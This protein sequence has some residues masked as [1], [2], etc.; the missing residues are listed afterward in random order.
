MNKLLIVVLCMIAGSAACPAAD[1]N[2]AAPA[3][4]D[5]SKREISRMIETFRTAIVAKDRAGL[6]GLPFGEHIT[7]ASVKDAADLA[8]RRKEHPEVQKAKPGSYADFVDYIV[9]SKERDEEKFSNIRIRTDGSI[10][11]VYFDYSFSVD[12][13]VTNRGHETWG[14]VDTDQGWKISSIIWSVS[15]HCCGGLSLR[16]RPHS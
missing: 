3:P 1:Q 8:F 2:A 12:G 7:F 6:S 9:S 15:E 5:A 14:L 10:A 4:A 11:D 13:S 16:D